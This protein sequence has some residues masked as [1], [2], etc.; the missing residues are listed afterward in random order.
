MSFGQDVNLNVDKKV[1]FTEKKDFI[2]D[3]GLKYLGNG[4]YRFSIEANQRMGW[5]PVTDKEW[6]EKT[7]EFKKFINEFTNLNTYSYKTFSVQKISPDS[8]ELKALLIVDFNLF[9]KDG[10]LVIK[11][12]EAK[13]Q[14]LELKEYL[15]LGIIT[16]Q[17]FDTKAVSLKKIL[18]GN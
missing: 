15:D 16:Q 12:D 18:L 5:K 7:L 3:L 4:L 14:I 9:N 17:E 13:Q 11:K 10:S 1:E 2:N 6:A 8:P